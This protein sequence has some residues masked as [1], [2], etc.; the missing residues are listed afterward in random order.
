[1]TRPGDSVPTLQH[2]RL[3][4]FLIA[5][6]LLAAG[7]SA[8]P[9]STGPTPSGS[10]PSPQPAPSSSDPEQA[11]PPSVLKPGDLDRPSPVPAALE[12]S[13]AG[14]PTVPPAQICANPVQLNGPAVPPA[15]SVT[16]RVGD[17]VGRATDTHPPGTTFW[18]AS[19]VHG[20]RSS[21]VPK[22]GNRYVGA[23]GAVID[24]GGRVNIAFWEEWFDRKVRDVQLSYLTIQNFASD[25]ENQGALY[26]GTGWRIDHST[27]RENTFVALF[28]GSQN[29][30]EYNCFEGNGQLGVGTFRLDEPA[31]DVLIDHNEFRYNNVKNLQN[32]GCA[33][34]MKFWAT[35]DARFVNN[36]VHSN[37]G[38]GVWADNNNAE[39]LFDGNYINDNDN[40]GIFYEISY[41]F[42][43]SNNSLVRN[44]VVKGKQ[45]D[46]T[47]PIG[48]VYVS[49]SG[50]V[51]VPGM[52][53]AVS[54][55]RNN[56]FLDNWDG[57]ALWESGNRYAG[58]DGEG[59]APAY[60]DPIHWKTQNVTVQSNEFVVDKAVIGCIGSPNCGR[61]GLFSD[62]VPTPG[63]GQSPNESSSKYQLSVSFDQRNIFR[64]N[65]YT[66]D[67]H[68]VA[69]DPSAVY[70]WNTWRAPRPESTEQFSYLSPGLS[71]FAQD[72]GSVL[73]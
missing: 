66:G 24:G 3:L 68:F 63:P 50:G 35:R 71:G 37:R 27:F 32:C 47:F 1:M 2:G 55:I 11:S 10:P 40:E 7:C 54:E 14:P 18:L 44:A 59:Y 73:K 62:W 42:L 45:K 33:G 6:S 29:V 58:T 39:M 28:A 4:T 65:S 67:W 34:G 49:E 53:Y 20:F 23:P 72:A 15:G 13:I 22:Q 5:L 69:Y 46:G 26:A 41:N 60:G 12:V 56:L 19:G 51:D 16:I 9:T 48:A 17:D 64:D 31:R 25:G 36:W 70:D 8:A 30:V 57:V 52:R 38:A 21:V 61:N 43:I